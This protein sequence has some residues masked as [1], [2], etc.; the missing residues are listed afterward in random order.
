MYDPTASG[1]NVTVLRNRDGETAV[2]PG[3]SAVA[4]APVNT[5]TARRTPAFD[6][7]R[8][9]VRAAGAPP[10]SIIHTSADPVPF[11][12]FCR[13]TI[14]H[15]DPRESVTAPV[16]VVVVPVGFPTQQTAT[17]RELAAGVNDAVVAVVVL[18]ETTAGDVVS[19][20]A[21][22]LLPDRLTDDPGQLP[23]AG[24]AVEGVEEDLLRA[25]VVRR[26]ERHLI[27]DG[28]ASPPLR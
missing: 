14:V 17:S 8:V 16:V 24:R 2:V 12:L 28:A 4:A 22:P 13:R 23:G 27:D 20:R 19:A 25:E 7:V 6:P 1:V 15:V 3:C 26:V 5:R 18:P 9:T 10:A 11:E 21:T